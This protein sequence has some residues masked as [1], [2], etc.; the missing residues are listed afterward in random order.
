MKQF[1]ERL[2]NNNESEYF[3]LHSEPEAD[4]ADNCA[5]VLR[6]SVAVRAEEHYSA[7]LEARALQL[8]EVFRAKLGW[9]VGQIYSRVGTEDW[10]SRDLDELVRHAMDVA[11]VWVDDRA[12][13][14]IQRQLTRLG[15]EV[16][17]EQIEA[18][19]LKEIISQ[20]PKR[21]DQI[22]ER[23]VEILK[24]QGVIV[25]IDKQRKVLNLLRSD[26]EISAIVPT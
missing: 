6:L 12:K 4:L 25:E 1:L 19:K 23:V 21:K 24:D 11:A 9:L 20:I 16:P 2:F 14:E 5:V 18:Q 15:D 17:H 10:G 8:K 26:P 13:K 7:C 3:Y 22:A